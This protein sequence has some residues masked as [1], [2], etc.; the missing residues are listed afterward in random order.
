M[1]SMPITQNEKAVWLNYVG[2]GEYTVHEGSGAEEPTSKSKKLKED[3]VNALLQPYG[4]Q[5]SAGT[6]KAVDGFHI[7]LTTS[8]VSAATSYGGPPPLPDVASKGA[9][10]GTLTRAIGNASAS[11]SVSDGLLMWMALSTLAHTAMR[12]MKD[13]KDI[14]NIMQQGKRAAA[15]QEINALEKSIE[16]QKDAAWQKFGISMATAAASCAMAIWGGK[17]FDNAATSEA[18]SRSIAQVLPE[19]GNALS[20]QSGAQ[21]RASDAQLEQKRME[22]QGKLYDEL[23]EDAKGNYEECKELFKLALKVMQEHVERET[24]AINATLRG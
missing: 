19:L 9:D 7:G 21:K 3:E 23:I 8:G 10:T 13:A 14:R 20:Q 1:S 2:D 5:M 22:M 17:M 4:L 11:E 6:L 24:Q 18:L 15:D 12:D 16:A